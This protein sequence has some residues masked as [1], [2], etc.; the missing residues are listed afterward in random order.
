ME[1]REERGGIGV[2]T[3]G[4]RSHAGKAALENEQAGIQLPDAHGIVVASGDQKV[5][6]RAGGRSGNVGRVGESFAERN[7]PAP[8]PDFFSRACHERAIGQEAH[9]ADI[10]RMGQRCGGA[11]GT[12]SEKQDQPAGRDAERVAAR[13][14]AQQRRGRLQFN[15]E[16]SGFGCS[17][18]PDKNLFPGG[19]SQQRAIVAEIHGPDALG[20]IWQGKLAGR[21]F[22]AAGLG[23]QPDFTLAGGEEKI[24]LR[25]MLCGAG[26][27][28]RRGGKQGRL[29]LVREDF[30]DADGVVFAGDEHAAPVGAEF[31]GDDF[32]ALADRLRFDPA[33]V[34]SYPCAER[35]SQVF[36]RRMDL[37][38]IEEP[39]GAVGDGDEGA[40]RVRAE[41]DGND[42]AA[43]C[44]SH[45]LLHQRAVAPGN[46][47]GVEFGIA[48]DDSLSVAGS[49][50][51]IVSIGAEFH[52]G[53][54]RGEVERRVACVFILADE[55]GFLA[56][57][58]N[59]GSIG[60]E[61][62]NSRFGVPAGGECG[63]LDTIRRFPPPCHS[64]Q[65]RNLDAGCEP[66]A[67]GSEPHGQRFTVRLDVGDMT[68][69]DFQ[70][71]DVMACRR[72]EETLVIAEF[73]QGDP[74][75][76][77]HVPRGDFR[78]TG[79]SADSGRAIL[80]HRDK[81][82][83][84][85]AEF[86]AEHFGR[87][88][89]RGALHLASG[90]RVPHADRVSIKDD[91]P[92]AIRT[93][94]SSGRGVRQ[95]DGR[96]VRGRPV[97]AGEQGKQ[98][99]KSGAVRGVA[100]DGAAKQ[101]DDVSRAG[102]ASASDGRG[103]DHVR[104][105]SVPS[106]GGREFGLPLFLA[107][108]FGPL[109]HRLAV[110]K[111]GDHEGG[112]GEKGKK[113][114][115][116]AA[117]AGVAQLAQRCLLAFL[118]LRDGCF[119]RRFPAARLDLLLPLAPVH[120]AFHHDVREHV[121][122]EFDALEVLAFLDVQQPPHHECFDHGVRLLDAAC[123]QAL[124]RGGHGH[125]FAEAGVG[126]Q[127][128][129]DEL[130]GGLRLPVEALFVEILQDAAAAAFE[131]LRRDFSQVLGRAPRVQLA[132]EKAQQRRFDPE[133]L[134]RTADGIRVFLP[135]V[136]LPAV[137][138][139][140]D[141]AL[142]DLLANKLSTRPQH[143]LH[144]LPAVHRFE[145][146][147][148]LKDQRDLGSQALEFREII[149][150]QGNEHA[151][152]AAVKVEVLDE[153]RILFEPPPQRFR[154]TVFHKVGQFG[155]QG[156]TAGAGGVGAFPEGEDFLELV[157]CQQERNPD[158]L[159]V[160]DAGV[161]AVEELPERFSGAW[162]PAEGQPGGLDRSRHGLFDLLDGR[163][164][165]NGVGKADRYGKPAIGT[166]RRKHP[167]LQQRAFSE[168]GET[169]KN[170]ERFAAH[171]AQQLLALG[172][173]PEKVGPLIL[174]ERAQPDPGVRGIDHRGL[175]RDVCWRFFIHGARA[176]MP[177]FLPQKGCWRTRGSHF[178]PAAR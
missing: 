119:P 55:N 149:F 54:L 63:D 62:Q 117:A 151:T 6:V 111:H 161:P 100:F 3:H 89:G 101:S 11:R 39:N 102:K 13:H 35:G 28:R 68:G 128:L 91:E 114:E 143:G 133:I 23:E 38:D 121:V 139:K 94:G 169:E 10:L 110:G 5:A 45:D 40:H 167:G 93:E 131:K 47:P 168:A 86:R 154:N 2:E 123:L 174:G 79:R 18:I 31:R 134:Q 97:R 44:G 120:A 84:I 164:G 144:R 50:G 103:G 7:P 98:G 160:E 116:G 118:C 113:G 65:A 140:A 76:E 142:R 15:E 109:A 83:A 42:R 129:L 36:V 59:R 178:R 61:R 99:D 147:A 67:V 157:E 69:G 175:G 29:H 56:G 49:G 77:F 162:L 105:G 32:P 58:R 88:T 78:G 72:R 92:A 165:G 30:P 159:R 22:R 46:G 17:Q 52:A 81:R 127:F 106:G 25:G 150:A 141:N 104:E 37:R 95:V 146:H 108:E 51:E 135:G 148:V 152:I 4:R 27:D 136:I 163:G 16:R 96:K 112:D 90:G 156:G 176:I 107:L 132:A 26:C 53:D 145:A 12:G 43:P 122:G 75:A 74:L 85:R 70:K 82:T 170:G 57:Y 24:P 171:Q 115:E 19:S 177:V 166:Q 173:A 172:L 126:Q 21:G 8:L 138:D 60:A 73:H 158:A 48:G 9:P 20:G 14:E 41:F 34:P 125:V 33:A 71:M 66:G 64:A 87:E 1:H 137:A 130:P 155:Q 80:Q 153:R 124:S